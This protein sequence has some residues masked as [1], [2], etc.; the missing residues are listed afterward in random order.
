MLAAASL[1]MSG[2]DSPSKIA[3]SLL[4]LNKHVSPFAALDVLIVST[5]VTVLEYGKFLESITESLVG[6]PGL[7]VAHGQGGWGAYILLVSFLFAWVAMLLGAAQNAVR[8]S[9][10]SKTSS[11]TASMPTSTFSD[12]VEA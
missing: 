10:S 8:A 2:S 11:T 3:H 6:A 5:I 4:N 9:P 7:I 1:L 12:Q